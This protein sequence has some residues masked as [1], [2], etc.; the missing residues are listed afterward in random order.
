M[1]IL[2]WVLIGLMIMLA[3]A[4]IFKPLLQQKISKSS[5]VT[6]LVIAIILPA[7]AFPTYMH[8]G[9]SKNLFHY[10]ALKQ[11]AVKVKKALA[12]IKNPQQIISMLKLHLQKHPDSA[13]GWYLLGRLYLGMHHYKQ[14]YAAMAKAYRLQALNIEYA[15]AFAQADFF[16]HHQHLSDHSKQLLHAV[17]KRQPQNIA[18]LNLIAV[19]AYMEHNYQRAI[20]YWEKMIPLLQSG[21]QDSQALLSMIARAQKQLI[22][23]KRGEKNVRKH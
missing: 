2:F 9:A 22:K 17:I 7:I 20:G 3:L 19:N 4:F 12:K 16:Y 10:W 15:V 8:F 21:S 18:A 23:Q 6:L 14:A 1:Q 13:K 11:E 5:I